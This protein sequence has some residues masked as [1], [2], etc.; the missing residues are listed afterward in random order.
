VSVAD[1]GGAVILLVVGAAVFGALI[2][3][4]F[5]RAFSVED[6]SAIRRTKLRVPPP[7]DLDD[8][9]DD[10]DPGAPRR[11]GAIWVSAGCRSIWAEW[12]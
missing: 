5:W 2:F 10:G 4:C 12:E 11:L 3:W 9:S 6:Y 7:H 1:G 8:G